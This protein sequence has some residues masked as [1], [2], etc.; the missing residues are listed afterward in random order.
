MLTLEGN[1]GKE[2]C[3]TCVQDRDG[4]GLGGLGRG[5]GFGGSGLS[6]MTASMA[7]GSSAVLEARVV[8]Q[9]PSEK[10]VPDLC[11]PDRIISPSEST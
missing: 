2:S 7:Q 6:V 10:F 8:S 5:G 1:E 9:T 3:S 4:G 11:H